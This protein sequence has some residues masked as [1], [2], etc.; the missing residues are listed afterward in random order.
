MKKSSF[1]LAASAGLLALAGCGDERS[2]EDYAPSIRPEDRQLGAEQHPQ[3]LAE[4]GGAY[5]APEARYVAAVGEKVARAAGLGGQCT[6]T[7]VNTDVVNAFAVPGCF[8]YITRGLMGIVNSEAQLASV[9][10]HEVGHIVADHSQRQ[11]RRSVLTGLGALAV[12]ILTG[13]ERLAAFAGRAAQLFGLRYSRN[14]EFESD[15]LG[16]FYT[17]EAGYDPFEAAEMLDALAR[18]EALMARTRGDDAKTIPAWART[19]PLT[20][21]RIA[22]AAVEAGETG[23]ADNA[24][25][26]GEAPF[27]REVDGLLYGDDP[28]QG[29][30]QGRRFLHPEMRVAFEAPPGFSLSNTPR[31][32]LIE[33]RDGMR[34]EFGGGPMPPSGVEEYAVRLAEQLVGNSRGAQAGQLQRASIGGV[35][36]AILP[37]SIQSEQGAA[38]LVVAAYDGGRG[39]AY[40]FIMVAPPEEAALASLNQLF[41][42]FRLLSA[43][44]AAQLRPRLIDVVAAGPTDTLQSMASRMAVPELPLETFLMLNDRSADQPLRAGEAVKIVR[45]AGR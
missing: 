23:V 25:P 7:L 42:S 38:T 9:L 28:I 33:G 1:F 21:D 37:V 32:V 45:Y 6:F 5:E 26:E 34:G 11:Q 39:G 31:A 19:H 20:E 14:Q 24:L 44:Q 27:L 3:L 4:F 41:G 17:K 12:G 22:R 29:F 43:E 36:A 13:S 16:I 35:P 2:P 8:I 40:H 10:G 18:N 15:R 30:V